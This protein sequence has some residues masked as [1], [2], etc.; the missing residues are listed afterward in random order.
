MNKELLAH[1][2][3][4]VGDIIIAIAVIRVH[5]GVLKEHKIDKEV[6]NSIRGEIVLASVGIFFLVL[7][8]ALRLFGF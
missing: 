8:F 1:S 7:A 4:F 5:L 2:L 6:L 3:E